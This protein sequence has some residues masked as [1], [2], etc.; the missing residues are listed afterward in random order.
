MD[1][2]CPKYRDDTRRTAKLLMERGGNDAAIFLG[3][4]QNV[5]RLPE[6]FLAHFVEEGV[7]ECDALGQLVLM[8]GG[9]TSMFRA[10]L[11]YDR[12]G[13]LHVLQITHAD[14]RPIAERDFLPRIGA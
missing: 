4:L 2:A 3:A 8:L 10:V 9:L 1:L 7:L 14:G 5:A 11:S 6:V 13:R 12:A